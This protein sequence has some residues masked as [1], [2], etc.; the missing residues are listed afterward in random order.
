MRSFFLHDCQFIVCVFH[1]YRCLLFATSNT[2][3][4]AAG[5][6]ILHIETLLG[7][8]SRGITKYSFRF[9]ADSTDKV[10]NFRIANKQNKGV[11]QDEN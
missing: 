11:M 2:L 8:F 5:L 9:F 1:Y 3:S 7:C 10:E 6:Q 4:T